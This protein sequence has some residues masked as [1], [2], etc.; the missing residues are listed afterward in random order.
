MPYIYRE[1]LGSTTHILQTKQCNQPGLWS[2]VTSG[3]EPITRH[4]QVLYIHNVLS[5]WM[6]IEFHPST[7]MDMYQI[8]VQTQTEIQAD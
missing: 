6:Q 3:R 8:S 5:K 2:S 1:A 4:N 7:K